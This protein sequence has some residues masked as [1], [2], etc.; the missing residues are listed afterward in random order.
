MKGEKSKD[1]MSSARSMLKDNEN[2]KY[3]S[4]K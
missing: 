2:F 4:Q 3:G 1:G